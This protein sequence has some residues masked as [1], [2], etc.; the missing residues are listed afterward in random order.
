MVHRW[1]LQG[2]ADPLFEVFQVEVHTCRLQTTGTSPH[3]NKGH[4]QCCRDIKS[5]NILLD[6]SGRAKVADVGLACHLSTMGLNAPEGTFVSVIPGR[7][8]RRFHAVLTLLAADRRCPA[9]VANNSTAGVCGC[10]LD[11]RSW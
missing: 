5:S 8:N 6:G 9:A 4:S 7:E 11:Q 10:L 3:V 2:H 1:V